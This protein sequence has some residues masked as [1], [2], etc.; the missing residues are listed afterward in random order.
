MRIPIIHGTLPRLNTSLRELRFAV[1]RDLENLLNTRW[2]H[3]AVAP[4][5]GELDQSTIS[6]G[7]P[8]IA[9]IN[10]GSASGRQGYLR[11]VALAIETYEPRL[12]S[13]RV[14]EQ[15][16]TDYL[17]RTLRFRIQAILQADLASEPIVF[18]SSLKPA[19]GIVEVQGDPS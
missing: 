10:I 9:A 3:S 17:D 13:V 11:T 15:K 7:L 4:E 16:N 6:Y 14:T 12:K 18:D 1:R 2:Y 8:D 19:T 5:L